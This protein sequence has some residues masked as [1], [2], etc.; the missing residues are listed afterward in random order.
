MKR[1]LYNGLLFGVSG[2]LALALMEGVLRLLAPPPPPYLTFDARFGYWRRPGVR[3]PPPRYSTHRFPGYTTNAFGML[4]GPRTRARPDSVLR[5][6]VLGD[7]YVEG[8]AVPPGTRMTDRVEHDSGGRMEVL[9]F[10]MGSIGTVQE[11]ALYRALVR[12]FHP[13]VVVCALL[14]VNDIANNYGPLDEAGGST[15]LRHWTHADLDAA[16]RLVLFPPEPPDTTA[17][18]KQRL[19]AL[20][21][22]T[23]L[24]LYEARLRLRDWLGRAHVLRGFEPGTV[25]YGV[26]APP[27]PG[28]AWER[29]WAITEETLRRFRADV[30]A[31]GA[32]FVL[33]VLSDPIQLFDDPAGALRD[34]LGLAVPEGF[35]PFYPADRLARFCREE[36]FRC[37]D[38]AH[39]FA[40]YRAA[41]HLTYPYFSFPRDGHWDTPGHRVAADTLRRFLTATFPASP[42]TIFD[43]GRTRGP[44]VR[45]P[46]SNT[47]TTPLWNDVS[48]T[49]GL[50]STQAD[51]DLRVQ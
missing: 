26:Y 35:D 29:A 51:L 16:G 41:H 37:L 12:S 38:L 20:M 13:D 22:A 47:N 17:G 32:A 7:S 46:L 33:V 39:Y 31:D 19:R 34:D 36:G 14:T 28:S 24:R 50:R 4:D 44:E 40:R 9:N 21:P 43:E 1:Y 30:E 45:S 48:A 6:A 11:W 2:V 3:I 49:P 5:V 42:E 8:R 15:F 18:F 27:A 10:G 23:Y 25:Y